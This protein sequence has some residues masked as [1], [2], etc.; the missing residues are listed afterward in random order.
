[1]YLSILFFAKRTDIGYIWP[2]NQALETENMVTSTW[3]S[4]LICF[5]N[6]NGAFWLFLLR[7]W[8]WFGNTFFCRFLNFLLEVL[9]ITKETL[10]MRF[11]LGIIN[12][13]NTSCARRWSSLNEII[14]ILVNNTWYLMYFSLT[15]NFIFFKNTI[16][17]L[18]FFFVFIFLTL[19]IFS[20]FSKF[21]Q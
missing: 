21:I 10:K 19:F 2:F 15:W 11:I 17:C 6:T 3:F 9:H 12:F 7:F 13:R 18:L 14:F 16:Q 1:M 8:Q 20:K 5:F 4:Y